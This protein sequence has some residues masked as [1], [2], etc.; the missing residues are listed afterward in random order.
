MK[1]EK[2][3]CD[4]GY[5]LYYTIEY[6]MEVRRNIN[7]TGRISKRSF[8]KSKPISDEE[9]FEALVCPRCNKCYQVD[10]WYYEDKRIRRG[11]EM[12][13]YTGAIIL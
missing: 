6:K 7:K 3:K 12:Y 13:M 8:F 10:P 2:P 4:C 5:E 9:G 11:K 1:Y